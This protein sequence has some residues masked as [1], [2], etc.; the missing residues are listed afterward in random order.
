MFS[1]ARPLHGLQ[2]LVQ[3]NRKPY[4]WDLKYKPT[5]YPFIYMSLLGIYISILISRLPDAYAMDEVLGFPMSSAMKAYI[6]FL[7]LGF[8]LLI[9]IVSKAK[10]IASMM[11][12]EAA[13]YSHTWG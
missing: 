11:K 13:F 1:F 5:I 4:N 6:I 7:L 12:D 3:T 10:V 2:G 9:E 8:V